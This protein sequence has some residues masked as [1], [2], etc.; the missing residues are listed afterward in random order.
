MD[1]KKSLSNSF[2][3]EKTLDK[4][5]IKRLS[6]Q[7]SITEIFSK[8]LIARGINENN[9]DQFLNP[10]ITLDL[11]NPF[12]LKDM[13]QAVD[14]CIKALINKE[15]IGII[16]DYDVDGSTSASILFKFL[17]NFTS[18][19]ICKIP[20]RLT[21]GFGPNSR[22]MNEMLKEN[23]NL[24]FTLDC[25]TSSFN[26]IDHSDYK[27]IDVIV[28]DHHLS[29]YKLPKVHSIINPNRFD[30]DNEYKDFAAVGV[31]FLFLMALRKEIRELNFFSNINEPNLI[32]YLDLVAIGTICDIVNVK[33]YNR[34]LIKKGLELIIK[35]KNKSITSIIDK[36]KINSIPTSRDIG[37][38]VGP[39]INAASRIDNSSLA[40][41]LLI[42]NDVNEI[43]IISRKLFLINE[44]RKLI[45]ESIFNE[46]LNQIEK[47][48]NHKFFVIHKSNWH[49]GVL[50]IVASKIVALYNKPTFILS[51][52][53]DIGIGSG[54]S[55][56]Q[57]DIGSIILELKNNNLINEGGGHKM[58]VGLKI[59]KIQLEDF[60]KYLFD[61][62]DDYNSSLFEKN[63]YYDSELSVNQINNKFLTTLEQLEPFGK[64]NE[65]PRFLIR[66][67]IIEKIKIIKNKHILIFFKNDL[68][69]NIKG[70]SFNSINTELGDYITQYNHYKFD[71]LCT[72]ERDNYT[73]N[74]IPQ[75]RINDAKL[76][77]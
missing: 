50:G 77:N 38:I 70:I 42:T 26:L 12:K 21:E 73:N 30:E 57:I 32:S 63:L 24:V 25:G 66:D 34:S 47:Q 56:D 72:I 29:E 58:A 40:S 22:L 51:F 16:A 2:W 54:R 37:F 35:R 60:K 74:D 62:F 15:K 75:I 8:L 1:K 67:I 48:K 3:K 20:N 71:F 9:F 59:N 39:Q 19:I 14:R 11:P 68:G 49:T 28:I 10:D 55:I 31:T 13:K 6:Q 44:K 27:K 23:I 7:K 46:A 52:N 69:K 76:I 4:N 43:E 61:K 53:N 33:N 17:K 64:G 45:E 36:S 5:K 41:K 18:K 65:E